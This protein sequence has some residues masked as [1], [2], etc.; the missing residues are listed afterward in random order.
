LY[1]ETRMLRAATM[2]ASCA[3]R[4]TQ[5]SGPGAGILRALSLIKEQAQRI[6]RYGKNDL[7]LY[8]AQPDRHGSFIPR[9][10]HAIRR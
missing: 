1:T 3:S 10:D 2:T 9:P 6:L 8:E 7:H 5:R 4:E